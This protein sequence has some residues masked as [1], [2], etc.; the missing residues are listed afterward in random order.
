MPSTQRNAIN[1]RAKTTI[2]Y[3]ADAH[4]GDPAKELWDEWGEGSDQPFPRGLSLESLNLKMEDN[5]YAA[6]DGHDIFIWGARAKSP[7]VYSSLD[8]VR[9][10]LNLEQGSV[11][12]DFACRNLSALDFRV[13]ADSPAV[14]MGCYPKGTIPGAKI[15]ILSDARARQASVQKEHVKEAAHSGSSV[16]SQDSVYE[17]LS[18]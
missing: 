11:L 2:N 8:A 5:L 17:D 6:G 7:R 13:Q 16:I 12:G 4:M 1:Y 14:K 15:G 10:E 3:R 9:K 18:R